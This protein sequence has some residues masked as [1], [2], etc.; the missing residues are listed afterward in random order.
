MKP[1]LLATA[2]FFQLCHPLFAEEK[3]PELTNV[4]VSNVL[5][6]SAVQTEEDKLVTELF[7]YEDFLY[8]GSR[9]TELG[10]QVRL[11]SRFR[12][13]LTEEAWTSLGFSTNP[14]SDRFDN[15][16][17]D[18]EFRTGYV[19][20]NLVGQADFSFNTNDPD[21]GISF[22][23]DLD[24]ENTFL[25][26]K[27]GQSNYQLTF[28]PFNFDGAVGVIYDTSDVT[29]I[30]YIQ[31][32][33]TALPIDPTASATNPLQVAQKTIPGF[34]LRYNNVKTRDNVDSFY[35]GIGAASYEYPNQPGFN[36]LQTSTSQDW[37]RK[38]ALGYKFGGL[39]RRPYSFNSL[40]FVSQTNSNETGTLLESAASFYSLTR[41]SPIMMELEITASEG[42]ENPWRIDRNG[43]F[44]D[45]DLFTST[46]ATNR[47]YADRAGNLQD[48]T[49]QWG[50]AQSL[51]VGLAGQSYR[52]YLSYRYL[53]EN[54]VYQSRI[55]AHNLRTNDLSQSHGGLNAIGVGAFMYS[56]NFIINPRFEYL[57]A[58][59]DVF[60]KASEISQFPQSQTRTDNDF[61]FFINVS[62]F[63]DV[64]TG[65]RTFR[66]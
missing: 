41:F 36:I 13:Q 49:G 10:D 1:Y 23:F 61:S 20:G 60:T 63:F 31:G 55:S 43:N 22:G 62:Y 56:G 57:K 34:V 44:G 11:V 4:P 25:R 24:S 15:K 16:T 59:N 9:K 19:Y 27:L 35:F 29:R 17:S 18:F 6:Q 2:L 54:F 40:Q 46:L 32:T 52:P 26:Y 58:S 39:L 12:Y 45:P 21:G 30:Y 42:G 5:D 51:K 14:D 33:P 53:D 3:A 48:W 66:L 47:V 65:P 38:E 37:S 28:F 64:R 8:T 7:S 50:F